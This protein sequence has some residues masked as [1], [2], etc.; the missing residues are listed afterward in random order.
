[1]AIIAAGMTNTGI[2]N[3]KIT[4]RLYIFQL[5]E[6]VQQFKKMGEKERQIKLQIQKKKRIFQCQKQLRDSLFIFI[7]YILHLNILK[8]LFFDFWKAIDLSNKILLALHFMFVC[9]YYPA[10]SSFCLDLS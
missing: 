10:Y 8:I 4:I 9:A 7:S 6:A 5:L 3:D 1:M 2:D